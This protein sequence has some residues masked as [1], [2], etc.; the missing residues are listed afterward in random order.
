MIDMERPGQAV[1]SDHSDKKEEI[2]RREEEGENGA[3]PN[4]KV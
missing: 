2:E 4:A 1:N 3:I